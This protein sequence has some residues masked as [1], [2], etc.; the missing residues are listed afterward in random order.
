[1]NS[2]GM[3]NKGLI[4]SRSV[5]PHVVVTPKHKIIKV[6][7]CNFPM[8]MNCKYA[9]YLLCDPQKLTQILGPP[10]WSMGAQL[11]VGMLK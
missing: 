7:S 8:V 9:E 11:E 3:A 1:M 10:W 6:Y 4:L 2:T 5:V